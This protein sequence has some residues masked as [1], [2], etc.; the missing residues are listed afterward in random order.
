[1]IGGRNTRLPTRSRIHLDIHRY[2]SSQLPTVPKNLRLPASPRTLVL[3]PAASFFAL[4]TKKNQSKGIM[5]ERRAHLS[6]QVLCSECKQLQ[7]LLQYLLRST[8]NKTVSHISS[9]VLVITNR[10]D[11]CKQCWPTN[12]PRNGKN[13]GETGGNEDSRCGKR[14]LASWIL[15]CAK[16]I[17]TFRAYRPLCTVGSVGDDMVMSCTARLTIQQISPSL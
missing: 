6:N 14:K 15:I 8:M 1:M 12:D 17:E 11:G 7:R 10:D 9:R 13:A 16:S 3:F 5:G 4:S 2:G